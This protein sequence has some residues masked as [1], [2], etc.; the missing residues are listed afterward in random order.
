[1][2]SVPHVDLIIRCVTASQDET[3]GPFCKRADGAAHKGLDNETALDA[4]LP[5]DFEGRKWWDGIVFLGHTKLLRGRADRTRSHER[6]LGETLSGG[7]GAVVAAVAAAAAAGEWPAAGDVNWIVDVPGGRLTVAPSATASLLTGPAV[8][9]AEGETS[10]A[11]LTDPVVNDP[12]VADRVLTDR[13]A[14]DPVVTDTVVT[15]T[16]ASAPVTA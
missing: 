10:S 6:G 13:G 1:M 15:D 14:T 16:G 9:V 3:A 7:T 12:V 5:L 4:G 11:W 8:I 2:T